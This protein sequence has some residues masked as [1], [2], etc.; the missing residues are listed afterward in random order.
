LARRA[1][2]YPGEA[3]FPLVLGFEVAGEIEGLES[4][5]LQLWQAEEVCKHS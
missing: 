3:A 5:R 4:Y 2:T 1:G